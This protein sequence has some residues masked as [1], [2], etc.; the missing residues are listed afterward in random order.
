MKDC[1]NNSAIWNCSECAAHLLG[2]Y[3]HKVPGTT[4]I[5]FTKEIDTDDADDPDLFKGDYFD[6]DLFR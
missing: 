4:F 3:S 2:F 1:I 6:V 5:I